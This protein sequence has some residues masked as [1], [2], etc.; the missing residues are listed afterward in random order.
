M[1]AAPKS[2]KLAAAKHQSSAGAQGWLCGAPTGCITATR[3][4]KIT[5]YHVSPQI[6]PKTKGNGVFPS[7][8]RTFS[9]NPS[10]PDASPSFFVL[11]LSRCLHGLRL[12]LL[13]PDFLLLIDPVG[14]GFEGALGVGHHVL[15]RLQLLLSGVHGRV[16]RHHVAVVVHKDT[17]WSLWGQGEGVPE[18]ARNYLGWRRPPKSPSPTPEPFGLEETPKTTQPNPNPNQ[19]STKPRHQARSLNLF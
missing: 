6:N 12:G 14:D 7:S 1:A 18:S 16:L 15:N 3:Q 8:N 19:P 11:L 9:T 2:R 13:P 10:P 5:Q 17:H 4:E